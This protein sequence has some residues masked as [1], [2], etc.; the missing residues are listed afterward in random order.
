MGI[1]N[2]LA[3]YFRNEY[4]MAGAPAIIINEKGEI[5]LG[6][7][8]S[9][10]VYPLYWNLPGG[11]IENGESIEEAI[12]REVKEE[13][14][15]EVVKLKR[16]KD[17]YQNLPNKHRSYH[18]IDIPYFCKIKGIPKPKEETIE[19]KWFKPEEIKNL[20]LAY[21]HKEILK[22]EGLI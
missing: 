9:H 16:G 1:V 12:K 4:V 10:T 5:L 13:L 17:I 21:T 6:K 15:V 20:Q 19:V 18:T 7:R 14:G 2:F 22:G 8:S 3:R 11:I